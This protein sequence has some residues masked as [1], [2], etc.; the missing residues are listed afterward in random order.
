MSGEQS[1]QAA[2]AQGAKPLSWQRVLV[3]VVVFKIVY[4]SVLYAGLVASPSMDTV[5]FRG[6]AIRWPRQGDPVFA[7][8]FA[9]W[10]AAHYLYLSEAGYGP[11]A[12][13][14]AFYPLWPLM[15]RWSA[16]LFGGNHVLA[17]MVLSNL[18]S[19][20]GFLV[21]FRVT[22]RRFGEQ[23]ACWSVVFLVSFPGSLFYQFVYSESLFFLLLMLLWEGLE[24]ER[25]GQAWWAALFLPL[26]RAVGVF[27]LL[28]IA[29]HLLSKRPFWI[30]KSAGSFPPEFECLPARI[31]ATR[32][33]R[34]YS[35]LAA[36]LA[37]WGIYFGL[38]WHWTGNPFWGFEAQKFWGVHSVWNLVNLPK[39]V[40]ALFSPATLHDFTGSSLDRCLFLLLL[41]TL[42]VVWKLGKDLVLWA[43]VLGI[44][45]AMSGEFTSYTRFAATAFPLFIALA[46][47]FAEK[48]RFRPRVCFLAVSG[49]LHLILLWQFVNFRWAG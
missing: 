44:M 48:R 13:S 8:H 32:N 28:P 19:T 43:Y 22:A 24:E 16:P 4:L 7:S 11:G 9:T 27:S 46:V 1:G 5:S 2:E 35:L 20:A 3:W 41:Y 30:A 38:M 14:C 33:L 10:D 21:F 31:E 39:F 17:G 15:M 18:L 25:Y 12:P 6:K 29:W 26:T 47:F 34:F 23:A 49:A 45:T 40:L 42:P 36:P 37:G